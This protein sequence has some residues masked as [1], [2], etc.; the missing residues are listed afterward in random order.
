MQTYKY[1]FPAFGEL[2]DKNDEQNYKNMLEKRLTNSPDCLGAWCMFPT[3]SA[4]LNRVEF[5][6]NENGIIN[7]VN[8]HTYT[9]L[10]EGREGDLRE[11]VEEN[12]AHTS[13]EYF[14][15]EPLGILIEGDVEYFGKVNDI[16][17]YKYQFPASGQ[18][19][20]APTFTARML[21]MKLKNGPDCLMSYC[22]F[23]TD[24]DILDQVTFDTNE[25]GNITALNL[26][27]YTQLWDGMENDLRECVESNLA[28]VME[29][30]HKAHGIKIEGDVKALGREGEI[31][32]TLY[33][34][35]DRKDLDNIMKEGLI[36]ATGD[37]NYKNMEDKVYLTTQKDLAPWL[38]ILK[39]KDNPVILEINTAG[40][41]TIETG[42]VFNDRDFTQ[43]VY[44]EYYTKEA[45]PASSISEVKLD[46]DY[47]R[48]ST[49]IRD[50]M[51]NMLKAAETINEFDEVM[52]G[53]NR[54]KNMGIA[55]ETD[56]QAIIEEHEKNN[57]IT[58]NTM[59]TEDEGLPWDEEDEE[60]PWDKSDAGQN[61]N[62]EWDEKTVGDDLTHALEQMTL[63]DFGVKI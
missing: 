58:G 19:N 7:G 3:D 13:Q 42:R 55:S 2:G 36:P 57:K 53:L 52:T 34:I 10:W 40:L 37:N 29:E 30:N 33:H 1:H 61:S 23:P 47:D 48:F 27:T 54:L 11:C 8:L 6:T 39:H 59:D 14:P 38:A 20:D 22:M 17:T 63:S 26:H 24:S 31:P 51:V 35:A 41:N 49:E 43:G 62:E 18:G 16:Q 45:I 21:E 50:R 56:G 25:K 44:T 28:E 46:K 5:E 32:T 12:I 9:Q 15:G 4:I 60:L